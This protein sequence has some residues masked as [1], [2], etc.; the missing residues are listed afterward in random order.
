MRIVLLISSLDLGGTE[1]VASGLSNAWAGRGDDVTLIATFSGGGKPFYE[2]SPSVEII[3][4]ADMVG[5]KNVNVISY[6]ERLHVLRRLLTEKAPD[7]IVSFLPN[8]NIATVLS[9]AFL[10]IPVIIGERSDPA[11]YRRFD[12]LNLLRRLTYRH[13]DMLTVQTEG[14]VSQVRKM[15]PGL[16][17]VHV[18]PNAL[19]QEVMLYQ[20]RGGGPRKILL[21]L[22]RLSAE[23]QINKL[24]HAYS[25]LAPSFQE[26]DLHIYG[27]G[28]ERAALEGNIREAGLQDRAFL[29]GPTSEPWQVMADADAF[30]L[31]SQ[32]EGFP[33][34]LLEAMGIGLPCVAFDCPR[35]PREIMRNGEAGLLI[36]LNDRDALVAA[37]QKLME[38]APLRR[39][40]GRR[41]REVVSS[42]YGLT[43]VLARWDQ[44]FEHAGVKAAGD[45]TIAPR[46]ATAVRSQLNSPP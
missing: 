18:V 9:S 15:Y 7:I 32:Y 35:G 1:R 14:V 4:L 21:S 2:I 38:D 16:K 19:P 23:K 24:L 45:P 31:V 22:G 26:W 44:L 46:R 12:T 34:A 28:P 17:A 27:D 41:A 42:Q 3:Y 40:L 20:Q 29:K 13:A 8:V 6:L 33:N 36:A 10:K 37:L 11:S 5:V 39:T 25:A 30:A 43:A